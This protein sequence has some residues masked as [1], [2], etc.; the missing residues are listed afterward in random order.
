MARVWFLVIV[1]I[2]IV[3]AKRNLNANCDMCIQKG[4]YW[5][6]LSGTQHCWP[7]FSDACAK[8][9]EELPSAMLR[10]NNGTKLL[11]INYIEQSVRPSSQY[12]LTIEY[13]AATQ[14]QIKIEIVNSTQTR[15][16]K[17][18]DTTKCENSECTAK[19]AVRPLETF[20]TSS[21]SPYEYVYANIFFVDLNESTLVKYLISCAC[22]C[23]AQPEPNSETCHKNGQLI[24]G[25]CECN[26]G[27]SGSFCNEAAQTPI[28]PVV[29]TIVEKK[30]PKCEYHGHWLS[31]GICDCF[32]G[33]TG[34][35]C[36]VLN[37]G[38][39][40][41]DIGCSRTSELGECSGNGECDAC[42]DACVCKTDIEGAQYLEADNNC[43]DLCM[44]V[45]QCKDCLSSNGP[46]QCSNCNIVKDAYNRTVSEELDYLNRRVWMHCSYINVTTECKVLYLAMR[47][48]EVVHIMIEDYC[49]VSTPAG[50][51]ASPVTSVLFGLLAVICAASLVA[52]AVWKYFNR[53]PAQ[54]L[55]KPGYMS[56]EA[57]TSTVQNPAYV[58]P[59][60]SF[61]NPTY[62]KC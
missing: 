33:W 45:E 16:L 36:N 26:D 35:N 3:F 53:I 10:S 32:K 41:G 43:V 54:D 58:T 14:S 42:G 13:N 60:S 5:C 37:C 7:E 2:Q 17:F 6:K 18:S 59:I 27:W 39:R 46:M 30:S 31:S 19:I 1:S 28:T 20:C 62:Q 56:V 8:N 57:A 52:V 34:K 47:E 11:S 4:G 15:N 23:S 51:F 9:F 38:R 12:E 44:T 29:P 61:I 21:G 55:I 48:N 22:P 25:I 50:L 40:R 24:C 49:E